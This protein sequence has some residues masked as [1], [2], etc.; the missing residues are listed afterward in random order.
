MKIRCK[1]YIGQIVEADG[2]LCIYAQTG[3]NRCQFIVFDTG[4]RLNSKQVA[5]WKDADVGVF[6]QEAAEQYFNRKALEV[7]KQN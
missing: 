2:E 5:T 4:N 6:T 7:I 1:P 3:R